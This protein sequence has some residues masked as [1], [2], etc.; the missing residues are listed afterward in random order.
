M[1]RRPLPRAFLVFAAL[2]L[3]AASIAVWE[4]RGAAVGVVALLIYGVILATAAGRQDAALRWAQAHPV[5]D[6]LLMAPLAFVAAAYA[7]DLSLAA[8]AA[9]GAGAWV[10]LAL[11]T[12][13]RRAGART[14]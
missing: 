13:R 4:R 6:T 3:I 1:A 9:V 12:L 11:V 10:L 2:V 14:A 8:C 5:L 7:T